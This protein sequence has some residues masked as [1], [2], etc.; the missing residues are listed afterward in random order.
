MM[1]PNE[2]G[3]AAPR[4]IF[5]F[6]PHHALYHRHDPLEKRVGD[7]SR[8][9]QMLYHR[10]RVFDILRDF[11]ARLLSH[12]LWVVLYFLQLLFTKV[13]QKGSSPFVD[14][15]SGNKPAGDETS[16]QF[17]CIIQEILVRDH[18]GLCR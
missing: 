15:V 4:F 16:R 5:L 12:R 13:P 10:L 17:S 2:P 9:D 14:I 3:V 7:L 6:P 8:L 1:T 11:I 18:P